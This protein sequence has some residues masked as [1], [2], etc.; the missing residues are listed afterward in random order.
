ML[1]TNPVDVFQL[2]SN[3]TSRTLQMSSRA[4][5]KVVL[6]TGGSGLVGYAIKQEIE[7]EANSNETWH[8]LSSKDA[9]LR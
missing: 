1:H 4:Q 6:V 8:F 3:G 9:D 5:K 7:K 2:C